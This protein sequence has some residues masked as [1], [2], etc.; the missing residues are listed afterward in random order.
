M[1]LKTRTA[2]RWFMH[3]AS[4]TP[5]VWLVYQWQTGSL[6]ANPVQSI[7]QHT[8]RFAVV[9]L[10]LTLACTPAYLL[11]IQLARD[12][13]KPLGLYTFFYAILHLASFTI[14]DYGLQIS[15]ILTTL[16][17][18]KFILFGLAGFII[19]LLLAI[20]SNKWSINH[21]KKYWKPL[22]RTIYLAGIVILVHAA[23]ARKYDRRLIVVYAVIFTFLMVFRIPAIQTWLRKQKNKRME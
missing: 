13:R 2:L 12:L 21:L 4:I 19:L 16:N 14:L 8:G 11:G 22:H 1:V 23:L 7:T 5:A 9:W 18:Q 6:G 10:L 3:A 20:T 17:D 15:L